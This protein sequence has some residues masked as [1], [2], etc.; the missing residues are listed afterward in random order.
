MFRA[1]LHRSRGPAAAACAVAGLNHRYTLNE[2]SIVIE[3]KDLPP[4]HQPTTHSQD[5]KHFPYVIVGACTTAYAA[6][7][8]ILQQQPNTEILM[9]S[10]EAH[11]PRLDHVDVKPTTMS[12]ALTHSYNEWRRFIC[13]RL[14]DEHETSP[15][16]VTVVL[17]KQDPLLFDLEAKTIQ[18]AD[19]SSVSYDKCLIAT[20]GKPRPLYVLDSYRLSYALVDRVNT[21][22]TRSDFEALSSLPPD[23]ESVSIIGGGLLA[24]EL[25]AAVASDSKNTKRTV[26]LI[27]DGLPGPCGHEVPP[28]LSLELKRRLEALGNVQVRP[29]TLVTSV[30]PANNHVALTC[31]TTAAETT[32]EETDYVVLAPT[33]IDPGVHSFAQV[34][35]L[36]IDSNNDGIVVNSQ[37]EAMADVFIAGSAASYYD[38]FIGRR[39][40]DRYDHAVNSGLLAGHNM[41]NSTSK[42]VYRHQPMFHSNMAGLGVVCDGVGEI[43]GRLQTI[44]VWLST[45]DSPYER[46]IVYY[47]RGHKLVGILLWNAPDL[48]ETARQVMVGKPTVDSLQDIPRVI[49]LGPEAWLDVVEVDAVHQR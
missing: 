13:P 1:L 43:D 21:A 14:E 10:D 34:N 32:Q 2:W 20:T 26:R 46:G 23:I 44:G 22:T 15:P 24:T 35:G 29:G 33:H 36:E 31:M 30:K 5:R 7:E 49:S 41:A 9:I 28:Y 25:A 38:E 3:N 27:F 48:V 8:A 40:L 4:L 19:G 12:D 45:P 16:N 17:A 37:L 6:I 11:L 42:K 18:I 39:R 47:L